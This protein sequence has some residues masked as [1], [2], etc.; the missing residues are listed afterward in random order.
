MM[1]MTRTRTTTMTRVS[2]IWDL[3]ETLG[4]C[5]D[6]K[7]IVANDDGYGDD[8]NNKNDDND[9]KDDNN[10]KDISALALDRVLAFS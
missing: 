9:D 4:F 2:Q 10:D 6:I 1:M 7:D 5:E 3:I 8:N